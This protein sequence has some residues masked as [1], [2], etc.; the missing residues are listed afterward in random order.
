MGLEVAEP[1]CDGAELVGVP[2][3][4]DRHPLVVEGADGG[5]LER[6]EPVVHL[7]LCT[8]DLPLCL[9]QPIGR[10]EDSLRAADEL[11][12]LL[13]LQPP[14]HQL[15]PL[16]CSRCNNPLVVELGIGQRCSRLRHLAPQ[17]HKLLVELVL[18][19]VEPDL[20]DQLLRH[21]DAMALLHQ[22]EVAHP[23]ERI[24]LCRELQRQTRDL[25]VD[26][27]D[28]GLIFLVEPVRIGLR[29]CHPVIKVQGCDLPG[30]R[31]SIGRYRGCGRD[32]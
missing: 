13:P 14:A 16:L 23:F 22:P 29:S 18:V 24:M 28:A 31:R 25:Q 19:A 6:D 2:R 10:E 3:Q 8:V 30:G 7:P 21:F 26:L 9:D 4:Q 11:R 27:V 15:G 12:D 17:D 5:I 32:S 20:L 1:V